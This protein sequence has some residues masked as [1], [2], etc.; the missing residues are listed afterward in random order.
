MRCLC[1]GLNMAL[2][3]L[4]FKPGINKD[5]TNYSS[6]G[7]WYSCDKIRFRQGFPEKIGGWIVQT[8]DQYDGSARSLYSYSTNTGALLYGVGTNTKFYIAAGTTLHDV[9]PIRASFTTPTTDDCIE[10]LNGSTTV[11]INIVGHGALTGDEVYISGATDVGGVLAAEINGDHIVTRVND[12]QVAITVASAATS[13]ATGG[14]SSIDVEF[15]I[16]T[17]AARATEGYGWGTDVWSR[18]TW[19]SGSNQ[20]IFIR[21]R[22]YFQ[23]KFNNDLIFNYLNGDIFY[24]EY[25]S[26]L[27]NRAVYLKDISGAVAVPEQVTK[28]LFAPTGHLFAFGCT[29]YDASNTP[30]YVG[31]FDPLLIR[32]ANVDTDIGPEPENW[33]PTVTNT[34]GFLRLKTGSE[35]ITAFRTRQ[36][37]L[38]WTDFSLTSI[39]FLGTQEVFGLQEISSNINIM[40]PKSVAE[41]NNIVYWMGNDKFFQYSGRVDTLPCTLK[42]HVFSN[43]NSEQSDLFFAGSNNE[44]NEVIWFYCSAQS[45]EIDSYVIYNH[46]EQIWY[47]GSLERT[48]WV[49]ATVVDY[50]T[51]AYDGY[52]YLHENGNDN[53]QPNGAAPQP[54][55]AYIESSDIDIEDGDKFMLLKKVIPDVSFISSDTTDSQ[56]G[57]PIVPEVT[58]T[59]GVR[60]FPGATPAT[61]SVEG[62]SNA[63]DIVTATATVD[64]YTNQVFIRARGRQMNFKIASNTVGTQWQLGMPRVDARLDGKRS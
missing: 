62:T 56:T 14:G 51:A 9:T 17:G 47:Y 37:T 50:P 45:N 58:M 10:T 6:E 18:L 40:G 8:F 19:G 25:S 55:N 5:V 13:D 33:Q 4:T 34:A 48:A 36:E 16:N 42:R 43:I 22:L 21:P 7:G 52:L 49:D 1:Q 46:Q 53:G 27:S 60:N 11:L 31:E 64:E 35:I 59:V 24:W 61:A 29:A 32:W 57:E 63:K 41:A 28:V 39:Q 30:T 12:S 20:P 23:D 54:L 44:F 26:A 2:T 3:K 15:E 38:V